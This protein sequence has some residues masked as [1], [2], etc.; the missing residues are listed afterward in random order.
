VTAPHLEQPDDPVVLTLAQTEFEA[1]TI[2]LALEAEG[3][4]A[5]VVGGDAAI[6]LGAGSAGAAWGQPFRVMVRRDQRDRAA[7]AL[8]RHREDSIDIDWDSVDVGEREDGSATAGGSGRRWLLV[9]LGVGVL[10]LVAFKSLWD[11]YVVP[12]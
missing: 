10:G 6:I 9:A 12:K 11:A 2:V 8:A 4:R 3:L 1:R 7:E 5:S